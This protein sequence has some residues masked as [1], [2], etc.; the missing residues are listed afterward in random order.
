[1]RD[2][3]SLGFV[4]S[5][6]TKEDGYEGYS[7]SLGPVMNEKQQAL[8]FALIA[9]NADRIRSKLTNGDQL[10][11]ATSYPNVAATMMP[12][13]YTEYVVGCIEAELNDRWDTIDAGFELVQSGDSVRQNGLEIVEDDILPVNLEYLWTPYDW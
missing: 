4:G 12:N 3:T 7:E 6:R 8:R 9:V 5:D 2:K 10:K 13:T 11:I 1:M